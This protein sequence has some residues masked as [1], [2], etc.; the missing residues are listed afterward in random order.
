MFL[1]IALK[2]LFF[3]SYFIH[4]QYFTCVIEYVPSNCFI[5]RFR[6]AVS[7]L[8]GPCC[9][10]LLKCIDADVHIVVLLGKNDDDDSCRRSS[11]FLCRRCD[12]LWTSGFELY[13]TFAH[14]GQ[15]QPDRQRKGA[16]TLTYQEAEPSQGRS[17]LSKT[18][19][20]LVHLCQAGQMAYSCF[21]LKVTLFSNVLIIKDI[22]MIFFHR[23][24]WMEGV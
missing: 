14:N 3:S 20:L 22:Q 9:P 17:L 5:K 18:A 2:K 13:V 19:L 6:A 23:S 1:G 4:L 12:M 7:V 24:R 11:V 15:E 8:I 21:I 16:C 10:A